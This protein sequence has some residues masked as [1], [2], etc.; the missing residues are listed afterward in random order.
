MELGHF[1]GLCFNWCFQ[2][3]G[4]KERMDEEMGGGQGGREGRRERGGREEG[5]RRERM[6]R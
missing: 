1:D 2:F 3:Q 4:G 6:K 5:W